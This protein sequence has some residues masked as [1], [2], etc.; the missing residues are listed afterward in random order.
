MNIKQRFIQIGLPVAA[1]F[2]A[3][4]AWRVIAE[5]KP[6]P[7]TS[8]PRVTP[9]QAPQGMSIVAGSGIVEPASEL[10][11]VA[12]PAPGVVASVPVVAGQRVKKGQALYVL[13]D[14]ELRAE[15]AV[16]RAAARSASQRIEVA[17]IELQE[18]QSS[19]D[20]YRRIGDPRAMTLE[21]QARREFAVKSA[22][23]RL[24]EAQAALGE[25]QAGVA[26]TQTRLEQRTVRSP[27]D[28]TVLQ[29]KARPGQYAPAN[30]LSEPLVTLGQLDPL[31]VRID[32]D[33]A[34]L[35]RL[36]TMPRA[37]VSPRGN[38]DARTEALLVR[39]EPLVIPKRSLTNSL[40]ERVDTR[41]MQAVFALPRE[42]GGFHVGQQVDAFI[43]AGGAR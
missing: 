26:A 39:V 24:M 10:I 12:N 22:K 6:A 19:L 17:E 42:V 13:D 41:V 21:E 8:P 7:D 16:R 3:A 23:A 11:A 38:K 5:G 32:I 2:L 27:L 43:A 25:A 15:L 18:K 40:N 36:G 34:D 1:M 4:S 14:A 35:A 28:A 30:Q 31:H 33:E 20:L 29:L 9:A 37:V